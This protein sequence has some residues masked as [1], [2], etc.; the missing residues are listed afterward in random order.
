MKKD[1]NEQWYE[2][3]QE[4]RKMRMKKYKNEER[5]EWRKMRMK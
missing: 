2:I 5:W 4:W 1:E 3:R